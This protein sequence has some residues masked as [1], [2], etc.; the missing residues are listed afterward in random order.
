MQ[1]LRQTIP[2]QY[3]PHHLLTPIA[4]SAERH[5]ILK[6]H[7]NFSESTQAIAPLTEEEKAAKLAELKAAM[8]Q[9]RLLARQQEKEEEKE[10]ERIRRKAGKEM[11]N[12]RE[13][14]MEQ[15]VLKAVAEKKREKEEERKAKLKIKE[16]IEQDKRD[17]AAKREKERQEASRVIEAPVAV[18]KAYTETRI[19]VRG[20]GNVVVTKT[21]AVDATFA[22]VREFVQD[23]FH[24]PMRLSTTFP[25]R[26]FGEGDD[27]KTLKELDLVPSALLMAVN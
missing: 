24:A 6:G 7:Q 2:Q 22:S 13:Q 25:R 26:V 17:R 21:F 5:A 27:G 15:Q 18:D 9:K 23:S 20:P 16:Q 10:K 8:E 14:F 12:A 1:R 19:Q 4:T 3:S 11:T